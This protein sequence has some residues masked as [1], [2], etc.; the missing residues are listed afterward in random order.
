MTSAVSKEDDASVPKG[1]LERITR[2][3]GMATRVGAGLAK[4]RVKQ[5]LGG[6]AN[7][8][9]AAATRVLETLG[10]LKGAA[11]KAGQT[12]SLFA[13]TL[14][15]EARLVLSKLYSQAPRV[16]YEEI[17]QVIREELGSPP[18]H[19]FAEFSHEP[20]A[21]ASLGQVHAA[22][23]KGG[24]KV[25]VK[26]QYPG[27]GQA[28]E[29]DLQNLG[30]VL[31][32]VGVVFDNRA[33]LNELRRE[34]AGE[35]DYERERSQ[36]EQFRG[37]LSRWP[38][39]VVPQA[40]PELSSKR[41]LT[42]ELL[43]GPT[44]NLA[45]QH[46]EELSND[47]R[48]RRAEQMIRAGWGPLLYDRAVHADAHPGNYVLMPDG[49][50][51]VLDFGSV[52]FLSEPFWRANLEALDSLVNGREIDWV[53]LLRRGGFE[54]KLPDDR[55]RK[56]VDEIKEIARKPV[57]GMRDFGADTTLNELGA[58]KLKYPLELL[59]ILPPPES[60]L[61]GRGLAGV[62]QN[63]VAL[64]ATGDLRPFFIRALKEVR[65]S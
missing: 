61:V 15:P 24:Q 26:V 18:E 10:T 17:A 27:I 43:E 4:D 44:L 60:I 56:L 47:E 3:A 32:A 33:Y 16:S 7:P 52:K 8:A 9:E 42:L 34:L 45:T 59:K 51:G 65:A 1:R 64:R 30:T 13:N 58:L 36:L 57:L 48:W 53:D 35:L 2:L 25:A 54:I 12:L 14:P 49:R 50:L 40:F 29:D 23:T 62:L 55:A 5:M 21:A 20:L 22:V 39:L 6:K 28:L 46:V 63:L 41:V 37:F 38:D 31:K 19:L 11:L